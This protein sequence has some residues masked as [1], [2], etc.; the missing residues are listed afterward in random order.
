MVKPFRAAI[1]GAF[2]ITLALSRTGLA[3]SGKGTVSGRVTD[4]AGGMLQG[5]VITLKPGGST[6]TDS[7]GEYLIT[8]LAPGDYSVS[9]SYV[10]FNVFDKGLKLTAG[11]SARVDAQLEVASQSSQILVTAGDRPGTREGILRHRRDRGSRA[12][13]AR[14]REPALERR[15]SLFQS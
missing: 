15:G 13:A 14:L 3:Q 5:A 10:G 2:I 1:C 9:V 8:G 11:Q 7:Q 4:S 12:L 6:S